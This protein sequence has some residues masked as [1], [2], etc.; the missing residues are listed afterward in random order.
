MPGKSADLSFCLDFQLSQQ[1]V[2]FF[3]HYIKF[4]VSHLHI[5]SIYLHK[6]HTAPS[7][8]A[9]GDCNASRAGS[10]LEH[11][12]LL[13]ET[14]QWNKMIYFILCITQSV[15]NHTVFN[16][17]IVSLF[18]YIHWQIHACQSLAANIILLKSFIS[19]T[20]H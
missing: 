8:A 5:P 4:L 3:V 2:V 1:K 14:Q 18:N 10:A 13:V 12:A 9:A 20:T 19:S 15:C 6:F 11:S 7:V 17:G 16:L